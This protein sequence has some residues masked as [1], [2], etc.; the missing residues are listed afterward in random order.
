MRHFFVVLSLLIC[1]APSHAD[2]AQPRV[3]GIIDGHIL[4]RFQTLDAQ[5]RELAL[6]ASQD[7]DPASDAL[8]AAYARAFDAW[9][10][11]SHLRF[12][13]TEVADRAFA[14]AFWPDARGATPRGLANLLSQQDPI[15]N[16]A[17][18]YA[19][20]SIAMRGFYALEY[21]LYD[22]TLGAIA[23]AAYHCQLIQTI[24]ADIAATTA[25]IF[26]DWRN[27]YADT[28][29][30]P[31]PDGL[32]RNDTE[33]L[34]ELFKALT[35]GLE[36]TATTR[37]GRPLG[38]FDRPRPLRAEAR[39]AGRSARHV[40]LSLASLHHLAL[41]L[42]HEDQTLSAALDQS[43]G[44][45]LRLGAEL[46]DPVFAGVSEPQSR[47]KVEVLQQSIDAIRTL[48]LEALG[49]SLGVAAGFNALDG[50]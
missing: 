5:S 2:G 40:A 13:P 30:T 1:P 43:F 32:Y 25:D 17:T 50:D 18:D 45:A 8:R 15:A 36:F 16:S 46:D 33:V 34:Q 9:V 41:G 23:P 12:G 3:D 28:L 29:R 20:V 6:V 7:C 48:A 22:E 10:S 49:P 27:S 31:S 35:T 14:L 26:D 39:R 42:S 44:R 37:L 21:L 47:L 11:A 4:T 24:S 38:T 19:Q